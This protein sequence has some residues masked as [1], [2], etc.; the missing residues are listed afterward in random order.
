MCEVAPP[1]IYLIDWQESIQDFL[2]GRGNGN[3]L[4]FL[5]G[6]YIIVTKR[7]CSE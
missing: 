7:F 5:L 1:I 6:M 3:A 2:L 4:A